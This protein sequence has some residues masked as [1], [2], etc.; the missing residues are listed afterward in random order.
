MMRRAEVLGHQLL[1]YGR[2]IMIDEIVRH[3]MNVT[4]KDVELMAQKL[5]SQRPILAAL[6]PLDNL[7]DYRKIA[8]RL[9]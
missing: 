9:K 1:N 4:K 2:P 3:V 7:E 6:G 5:L 8:K